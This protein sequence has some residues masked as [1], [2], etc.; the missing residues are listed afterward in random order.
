MPRLVLLLEIDFFSVHR[1]SR[2]LQDLESDPDEPNMQGLKKIYFVWKHVL[3]G[4][5]ESGGTGMVKKMRQGFLMKR[6]SRL[7]GASNPYDGYYT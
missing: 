6:N 7:G 5:N 4:P 2:R 3:L 1:S